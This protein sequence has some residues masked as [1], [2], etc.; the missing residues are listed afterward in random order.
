MNWEKPKVYAVKHKDD[1]IVA[2]SR[3]GGMF[4]AL[5]DL[6]LE[7]N[8]VVYGCVL[9]EK[10]NAKHI[11]ADNKKDRDLMRGSKY[12]ESK[13]GECFRSVKKDVLEGKKVLFSGT[14]CQIAGLKNFLGKEYENLIC[15]D[16]VC[17][18]VP[19]PKI[20]QM[21]LDWQIGKN[22]RKVVKVNFRNKIK[23]GWRA[24]TESLVFENGKQVNSGVFRN[25][26]YSHSILRESCYRCP[27]K[28]IL[29]PGDITIADY[30]GIEKAAPEFDDNKGVSLV[31]I[32]NSKGEN[33][34]KEASGFIKFKE[35]L[36]EDSMQG[37]LKEP[38]KKPTNRE[39]FW[40]D[41]E[42]YDFT[43]IAKKYGNYGLTNKVKNR[44]KKYLKFRGK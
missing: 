20:W 34:F 25:L 11:R 32:N 28:S 43:Y 21:Y 24:H 33:L 30:W 17:H 16:I 38:S 6:I 23:Y 3:S 7:K 2:L 37:P 42:K 18:G 36:L 26:F 9:D 40:Q 31:L 19:S 35:T 15:L 8:G 22:K 5:S 1:N 44:L 14:S 4:T 39:K 13:M 12:I 41:V 27:Y 10:F 29:H